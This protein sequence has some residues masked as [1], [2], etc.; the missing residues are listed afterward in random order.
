M[1]VTVLGAGAWGTALALVLHQNGHRITVWGHDPVH[2]ETMRRTRAN[3]S[4]LPGISIPEDWDLE[5]AA[6]RAVAGSDLVLIVVPS[7][8]F[9]TVAQSLGPLKVPIVTATK[10]IEFATGLTMGGVLESCFPGL[11]VAALSGPSLAPE[12]ARGVPTAVVAAATDPDT[13]ASIQA[14]FHRPQFR[15]YRSTDRLGVE[16]G[17][18]LKNIIAIGAGVCDGLGFGDNSKAALVTRGQA[19][20]RRL[21]VAC[22][23]RPETFSGLSGLGDLTVTCF[24]KMSRNRRLGERLGHGETLAQAVA[25]SSSVAEGVPTTRSALR[26]A[27]DRDIEVPIIHEIHS[28]LFDDKDV[29]QGVRDL[30]ARDLKAED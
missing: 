24:S 21:G 13:A 7:Q 15:V 28:M 30:L 16:L 3:E 2:L 6:D 17:G 22:G 29:R 23:A 4:Y 14:A 27:Q 10:G 11:P 5:P 18:A 19:E 25:A 12:V 26:L 1:K 9:R 20:V 8:A